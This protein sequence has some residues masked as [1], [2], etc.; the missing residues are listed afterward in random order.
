MN[1]KKL[2]HDAN[3]KNSMGILKG[4]NAYFFLMGG[5]LKLKRSAKAKWQ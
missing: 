4:I 2:K 5:D 3:K 1:K